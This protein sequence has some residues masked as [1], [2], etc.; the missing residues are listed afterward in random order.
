LQGFAAAAWLRAGWAAAAAAGLDVYFWG[1]G[2]AEES[3]GYKWVTPRRSWGAWSRITGVL[4]RTVDVVEVLK[5]GID[6]RSALFAPANEYAD[7]YASY[8]ECECN[9]FDVSA[10]S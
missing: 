10:T 2:V 4:E 3:P 6:W 7:K 5:I 9:C 1:F 8:D